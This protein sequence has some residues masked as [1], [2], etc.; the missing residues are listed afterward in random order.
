MTPE[1]ITTVFNGVPLAPRTAVE[2]FSTTLPTEIASEDGFLRRV[3]RETTIRLH[4][5]LSGETAA[6]YEMGIPVVET[7]DKWHYD[8]G[9]KVPLTLDRENVHPGFLRQVRVTVFNRMHASLTGEDMNSE[10]AE[11]ASADSNCAPEAVQTW[12]P[13]VNH[14]A[15]R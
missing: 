6:V 3:N 11:A 9:Q 5:V 8:I 2:Q 14:D 12:K 13:S 10:W 4:T 7:G 1:G 15:P